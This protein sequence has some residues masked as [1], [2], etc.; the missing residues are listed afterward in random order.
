MSSWWWLLENPIVRPRQVQPWDNDSSSCLASPIGHASP[1]KGQEKKCL[2]WIC[3]CFQLFSEL[4]GQIVQIIESSDHSSSSSFSQLFLWPWSPGN[5]EQYALHFRGWP[6]NLTI[7]QFDRIWWWCFFLQKRT[8][9][10]LLLTISNCVMNSTASDAS[11]IFLAV[12]VIT[13]SPSR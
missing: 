12:W 10:I 1:E 6:G 5:P 2:P 9:R 8:N 7:W 3:L 13:Y 4:T 11:R